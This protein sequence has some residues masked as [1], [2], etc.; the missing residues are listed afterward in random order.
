[1]LRMIGY[2]KSA[3]GTNIYSW[4]ADGR[5]REGDIRLIPPKREPRTMTV[6]V[7][8]QYGSASCGELPPAGNAYRMH[9]LIH[10]DDREP[11]TWKDL[12]SCIEGT[13]YYSEHIDN[14]E[15]LLKE[16]G[17]N[18]LLCGHS[19]EQAVLSCRICYET[20]QRE[21]DDLQQQIRDM[22][23]IGNQRDLRNEARIAEPERERDDARKQVAVLWE[24]LDAIDTASDI[25]KD[26][27]KGLAEYVYKTQR[28]RF[29][30]V[31]G[32]QYDALKGEG[33]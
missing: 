16:R 3:G 20:L 14:L 28:E 2:L 9:T 19:V 17:M 30:V 26:N 10:P 15:A 31:S 21:R 7:D 29:S 24:L 32:E 12:A 8:W 6:W 5:G 33:E 1:M 13:D 27:Y 4:F 22:D 23:V 11:I 18:D 25:F